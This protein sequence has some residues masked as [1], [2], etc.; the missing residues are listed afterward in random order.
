MAPELYGDLSL[1]LR[2]NSTRFFRLFDFL[3]F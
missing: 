1:L 3:G 2:I